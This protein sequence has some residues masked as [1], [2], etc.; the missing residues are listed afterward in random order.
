MSSSDSIHE[1]YM[2]RALALADSQLGQTAPNPSV[3][4]VIVKG[5]QVVGK[6]VTANG[7]RPHAEVVALNKA[8][9]HAQ[10][11]TAY[12]TLEPCCHYGKTPPCTEALINAGIKNVF[13]ATLDPFAKVN[14]GG[15]KALEKAGMDVMVGMCE[16]D[17]ID[18]NRGFFKVCRKGQPLVTLKLATSLDAKIATATG[19]SQWITNPKARDYAHQLRANHDAIM[20]GSGTLFADNPTLTCRIQGMEHRTPIRI[21]VDTHARISPD[22]NLVQT[23]TKEQPVRVLTTQ[24]NVPFDH[25]F[26]SFFPCKADEANRVSMDDALYLLAKQGITR[27]LVEGGASLA[28]S[29]MQAALIDKLIWI[30]APFIIGGDGLPALARLGIAHIDDAM[31]LQLKSSHTLGDNTVEVYDT[32]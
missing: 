9:H 25:P 20:V 30:R 32:M 18:I 7:G 29:M 26:V 22:S 17:A 1:T 11:A 4:C 12:V 15:V 28:A 16:Q 3:G 13:I 6:G 10:G 24:T 27:L 19:H 31:H 8:K 14:G 23:A 21:V 5:N 2:R